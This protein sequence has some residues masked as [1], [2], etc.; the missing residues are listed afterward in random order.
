MWWIAVATCLT[1]WIR[2]PSS[3][4]SKRT[5]GGAWSGFFF[6]QAEDGIR[7]VAVTGVQTCALPIFQRLAAVAWVRNNPAVARSL[8]EEALALWK[9]LGDKQHV[10]WALAWLAYMASQRGE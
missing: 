7:D 8:T 10:A 5:C 2:V 1:C 6:F 4:P 9:E 3:G